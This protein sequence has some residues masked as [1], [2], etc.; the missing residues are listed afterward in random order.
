MVREEVVEI[1]SLDD[2]IADDRHDQD[3][4]HEEEIAVGALN[5]AIQEG[6]V[7]LRG[8]GTGLNVHIDSQQ[9]ASRMQH[10]S[11]AGK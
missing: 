1:A 6:S 5:L 2:G 3:E 11:R 7:H 8:Y 4:A 9:T 10:G